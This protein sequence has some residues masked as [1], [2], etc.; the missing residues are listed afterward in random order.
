MRQNQR[1]SNPF[2]KKQDLSNRTRRKIKY[3]FHIDHGRQW[4]QARVPKEVNE[5]QHHARTLDAVGQGHPRGKPRVVGAVT[6]I[7]SQ[8]EAWDQQLLRQAD[9]VGITVRDY[10]ELENPLRSWSW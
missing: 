4:E 9:S 3:N 6:P 8:T 7:T 5:L 1:G 2:L 10:K